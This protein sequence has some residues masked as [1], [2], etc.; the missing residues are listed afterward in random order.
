VL[1][2]QH[3][4]P[5]L[6]WAGRAVLSALCRLLPGPQRAARLVTPDPLLAWHRRLARWRR[7]YP[8]HGGRPPAGARVAELIR[9]IARQ[10]RGWG[11]KRIQG[12]LPG[13]GYRAGAS[14]ARRVPRRLRIPPAPQR[15][16]DTWRQFPRTRAETMLACG[17]SMPAA[18]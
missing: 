18:R 2:P 5:K 3:R 14:A 9:Q 6:E 13:P 10:N 12:E 1:R 16:R 4:G 15:G 17:F 7:A 8:R 11:C